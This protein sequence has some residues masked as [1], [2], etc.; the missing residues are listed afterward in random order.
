MTADEIRRTDKAILF[1][2]GNRPVLTDLPPIAA[3]HPWR[4]QIGNNPF[5]GKPFLLPIK[6][7]IGSRKPPLLVRIACFLGRMIARRKI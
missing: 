7:R 5:Y 2:R 1:I 4:K 6:L 3:I